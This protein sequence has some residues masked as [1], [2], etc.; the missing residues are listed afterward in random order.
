M[1]QTNLSNQVPVEKSSFGALGK[2]WMQVPLIVRAIIIGFLVSSVGIAAWSACLTLIPAPWSI[3]PMIAGLW[4]YWK[5]FSGRR[6]PKA[7]MATRRE[8]FRLI[9]LSPAAWK[10]GLTAAVCFVVIVQL[11]FVLTF[12]L[13]PFPAARFTA[14]YKALDH[15]PLRVAFAIIVMSSVVAAICEE[16]G[17]RGYLQV[18][19]EKKY[20]PAIAIIITSLIFTLIHMSHTWARQ[21]IPHI[22]LASVLLGLLAYKT[23]SLI[24][25]I[26]GHAILDI[27]D[28]SIW[29]TDLAGGFTRQPVSRT[30]ID[31]HFIISSLVFL[32]ALFVF[33]RATGRLKPAPDWKNLS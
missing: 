14:D 24:P 5:I 16:T 20:G 3:L 19:L 8:N 4:I 10:W 1:R 7:G 30:G 13:L 26:I 28:Y 31:C 6:G 27:F 2:I 29:W 32:L 9:N 23:G 12:R 15:L 21:I 22:F 18:P 25:G 33:F 11:S 17:F